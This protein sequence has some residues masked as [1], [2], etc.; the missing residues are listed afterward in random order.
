[1][2]AMPLLI[3]VAV[4]FLVVWLAY[5]IGKVILRVAVGLVFM[6]L[7]AFVLWHYVFH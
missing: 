2:T 3:I 1:M 4:L 6:G 5:K 7:I